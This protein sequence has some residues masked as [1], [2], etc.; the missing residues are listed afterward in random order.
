MGTRITR[1]GESGKETVVRNGKQEKS[2][3][4]PQ[5]AREAFYGLRE[6]FRQGFA[7]LNRRLDVLASQSVR[8]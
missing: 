8:R 2:G 5:T 6:E 7:D 3:Q 4:E 1:A